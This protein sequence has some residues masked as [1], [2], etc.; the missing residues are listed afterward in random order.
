MQNLEILV[1]LLYLKTTCVCAQ[2]T[3]IRSFPTG[4]KDTSYSWKPWQNTHI[5]CLSAAVKINAMA[6]SYFFDLQYPGLLF[7]HY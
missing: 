7:N 5:D 4:E 3:Q 2:I 6:S 1:F